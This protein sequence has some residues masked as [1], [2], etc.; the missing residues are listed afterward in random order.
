M[1]NKFI[2]YGHKYTTFKNIK[3]TKSYKVFCVPWE[4][5]LKPFS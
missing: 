4:V 3:K 5:D 1:N 2:K